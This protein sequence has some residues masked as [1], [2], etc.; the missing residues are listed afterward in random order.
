[1]ASGDRNHDEKIA[2]VPLSEQLTQ[3]KVSPLKRYQ[4]KVLGTSDWLPFSSMN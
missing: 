4:D 2:K 3:A 1:M